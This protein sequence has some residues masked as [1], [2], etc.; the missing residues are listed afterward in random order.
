[1]SDPVD[2]QMDEALRQWADS[3]APS[4]GELDALQERLSSAVQEDPLIGV[5]AAAAPLREDVAG[6]SL[7]L[8]A[9]PS[10]NPQRTLWFAL[11]VAASLLVMLVVRS[12]LSPAP[13]ELPVAGET[14]SPFPEELAHDNQSPHG[15]V[16]S[17]AVLGKQDLAE[18]AMLF[19]AAHSDFHRQ[20]HWIAESNGHVELGL[21]RGGQSIDSTGQPLAIRLVLVSRSLGETQWQKVWSQDVIARNETPVDKIPGAGD[22]H[23]WCYALPDGLIAVES[24]LTLQEP[25]AGRYVFNSV[26][27]PGAAQ[28]ILSIEIDGR[29]YA[30]FQAV[31]L[32]D[33]LAAESS[34]TPP[35][36]ST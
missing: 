28:R 19:E 15:G 25:V 16:P 20:L 3:H 29:E 18:K 23:V 35:S 9:P 33:F 2:K 14:P 11:G 26:Q 27:K 21:A 7:W 36:R 31:S 24:E 10:T 34:E 22:L 17:F 13:N 32:L 30:L 5:G 6:D 8:D 1:M 4:A 12:S